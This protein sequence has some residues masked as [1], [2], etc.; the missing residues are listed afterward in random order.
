MEWIMH[1]WSPRQIAGRMRLECHSVSV[2]YETNGKV[3]CSLEGHANQ[4]MATSTGGETGNISWGQA[5]R[6]S[7]SL[8]LNGEGLFGSGCRNTARNCS[9]SSPFR[10][11]APTSISL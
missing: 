11:A 7:G 3:A 6:R 2:T 8:G 1:G 9:R 4:V 5:A 10:A